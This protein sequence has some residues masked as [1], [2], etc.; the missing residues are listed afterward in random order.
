[1]MIVQGDI[2]ELVPVTNTRLHCHYRRPTV[3]WRAMSLLAARTLIIDT[4]GLAVGS[5][6]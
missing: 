4:S 2:D 5:K 3:W 6:T 1:V